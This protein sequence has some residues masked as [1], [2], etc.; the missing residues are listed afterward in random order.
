MLE[1]A[2]YKRIA[3]G[4]A[5]KH[6]PSASKSEAKE[7]S[8]SEVESVACY[9]RPLDRKPRPRPHSPLYLCSWPLLL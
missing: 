3:K 5:L 4:W 7:S 6:V 2:F 8:G 1:D 9:L